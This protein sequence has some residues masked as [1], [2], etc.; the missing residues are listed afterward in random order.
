MYIPIL[1]EDRYV[2]SVYC[3]IVGKCCFV[4]QSICLMVDVESLL[5]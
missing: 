3:S 5:S 1:K 2:F 4:A